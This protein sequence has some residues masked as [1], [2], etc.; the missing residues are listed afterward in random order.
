MTQ[1]GLSALLKSQQVLTFYVQSTIR[2]TA[3]IIISN[4]S[5]NVL[6]YQ[7]SLLKVGISISTKLIGGGFRPRLFTKG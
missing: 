7:N 5:Y 3:F 2:H 1:F 6:G 4:L